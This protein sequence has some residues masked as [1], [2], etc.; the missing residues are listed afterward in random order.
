[1]WG[2]TL[3]EREGRVMERVLSELSSAPWARPLVERIDRDGGLVSDNMPLL[4]EAR[5]AH[6]LHM[7]GL[8]PEYEFRAGIGDS[9][10]DF[11]VSGSKDWLFE[12]TSIRPSEAVKRA[13]VEDG[14]F[15]SKFLRSP[16]AENT[17][18]ENEESEEGEMLLA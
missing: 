7:Q 9:V 5:I 10:I 6:A 14:P 4:F 1:M 17:S 16:N 18:P 15:V 8:T 13:T 11:C 12:L 3:S 2:Q